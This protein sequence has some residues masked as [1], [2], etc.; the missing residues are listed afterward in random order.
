MG[1]KWKVED[2]FELGLTDLRDSERYI[3]PADN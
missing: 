3:Y 2:V 1:S